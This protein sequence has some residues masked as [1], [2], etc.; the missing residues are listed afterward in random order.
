MLAF[1]KESIDLSLLYQLLELFFQ[2]I[3]V[4]GVVTVVSI[5]IAKLISVSGLWW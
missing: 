5:E 2:G 1:E 4:L 3:G